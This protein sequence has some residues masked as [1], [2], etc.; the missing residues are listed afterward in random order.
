MI[1]SGLA[2]ALCLLAACGSNDELGP[3]TSGSASATAAKPAAAKPSASA[4]ASAAPEVK[5]PIR[6]FSEQD[7]TETEQSRDPFRPF[8]SLFVTQAK[9]RT[10]TIK[11]VLIEKH[12]LDELRLAAIIS[13]AD[14]RALLMDPAGLGWIAKVG[15]Y[16]GKSEVVSAGGPSGTEIAMHWRIDRIREADIVLIR[17]DA[18]HPEIPPAT[19]I[20][21]LR[22]Q[23]AAEQPKE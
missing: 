7:F 15:D 11:S 19:R 4:A 2:A 3:V 18:G 21:A 10:T 23:E 14:A 8:A 5:V 13:G 16:L 6:E 1:R 20:I 17:E 9:S 22:P 12:A